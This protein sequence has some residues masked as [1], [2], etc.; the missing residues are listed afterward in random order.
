MMHPDPEIERMM[1][2]R[3]R[4]AP[5]WRKMLQVSVMN[6]VRD[7]LMR[8]EILQ[9]YPDA[10]EAE[11]RQRLLKRSLPPDVYEKFFGEEDD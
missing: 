10:D 4:Q 8:A 1:I 6:A 3:W 9:L 11:I 2:E 7:S 5:G